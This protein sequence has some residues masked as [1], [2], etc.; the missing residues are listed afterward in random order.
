MPPRINEECGDSL[1]TKSFGGLQ[2]VET[3]YKHEARA[4]S[5]DQDRRLQTFV[6]NAGRDLVYS[7]LFEGRTTLDRNVDIGDWDGLAPHGS[8]TS[9]SAALGDF[10]LATPGRALLDAPKWNAFYK[11]SATC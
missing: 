11:R 1:F 2:P 9:S 6:E 4:V 8:T 10:K 3:L 7:L 5:P